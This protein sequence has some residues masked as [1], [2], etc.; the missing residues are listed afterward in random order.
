M[1][2]FS[3]RPIQPPTS[4]AKPTVP[5]GIALSGLAGKHVF[6]ATGFART[7]DIPANHPFKKD[8]IRATHA[9][10]PI[11]LASGVH[12]YPMSW[13]EP[14]IRAYWDRVKADPADPAAFD[15]GKRNRDTALT[16]RPKRGS[17]LTLPDAA[18]PAPAPIA[19]PKPATPAPAP[20][21]ATTP[22]PRL[23]PDQVHD[24]SGLK[25]FKDFR[26]RVSGTTI[27]S[28]TPGSGMLVTAT[29]GVGNNS[30][31]IVVQNARGED[32]YRFSATESA[33]ARFIFTEDGNLPPS[34]DP[35]YGYYYSA[36]KMGEPYTITASVS[37]DKTNPDA[38]LNWFRLSVAG[39]QASLL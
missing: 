14:E 25:W 33:S 32:V 24:V 35:Y 19:P 20:P 28:H 15:H 21:R 37:A 11:E 23:E 5:D 12:A 18:P 4:A 2:N 30:P 7:S 13:R 9:Q 38:N 8:L 16:D 34:T 27:V 36:L 31:N 39:T 10:R 22:A 6:N 29:A 3:I 1:S 17:N 26:D